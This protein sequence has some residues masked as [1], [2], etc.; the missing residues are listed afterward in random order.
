MAVSTASRHPTSL[1]WLRT[2]PSRSRTVSLMMKMMARVLLA[3]IATVLY[4]PHLSAMVVLTQHLNHQSRQMAVLPRQKNL[5]E[6]KMVPI[7][8]HHRHQRRRNRSRKR[9]FRL[10]PRESRSSHPVVPIDGIKLPTISI[11]HADQKIHDR[12]KNVSKYSISSRI[13]QQT[14]PKLLLDQSQQMAT[15]PPA[16]IVTILMHGQQIKT[17]NFKLHWRNIQQVWTRTNGGR[18]SV[19]TCLANRRKIVSNDSRRSV[20]H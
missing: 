15:P 12:K 18:K 1:R 7:R 5:Q 16:A 3:V 17:T 10:S 9:N 2:V 8:Q 13:R 14:P 6:R 11:I 19:M 4:P 20:M